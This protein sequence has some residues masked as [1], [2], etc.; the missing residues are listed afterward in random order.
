MAK[1]ILY[2]LLLANAAY[3]DEFT[4]V[5][6]N[7]DVLTATSA[8]FGGDI[9]ALD[10]WIKGIRKG[11]IDNATVSDVEG[12]FSQDEI[13]LI[14]RVLGRRIAAYDE[15]AARV[16]ALEAGGVAQQ[17]YANGSLLQVAY[18]VEAATNEIFWSAPAAILAST[19]SIRRVLNAQVGNLQ[20]EPPYWEYKATTGGRFRSDSIYSAI[21][22]VWFF[23]PYD[24]GML[25]LELMELYLAEHSENYGIVSEIDWEM[26]PRRAMRMDAAYAPF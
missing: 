6:A 16:A 19:Q 14:L 2:F 10:L 25:W 7:V 13:E 12:H 3:A 15:L 20:I 18:S 17:S 8:G 24:S 23:Q 26:D 5:P 9:Y 21:S 11:N 22:G 4:H 1:K